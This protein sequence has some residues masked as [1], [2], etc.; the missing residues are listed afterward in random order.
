MTFR[1]GG[2]AAA[3]AFCTV[4]LTWAALPPDVVLRIEPREISLRGGHAFAWWIVKPNYLPE[5]LIA[6]DDVANP[7]S[8]HLQI[9][10]QGRPI[11]PAHALHQ[12]IEQAGS[13]RFSHWTTTL[14]F[15]TS[16]NTDPRT[17][18][19]SYEARVPIAPPRFLVAGAGALAALLAA[20]FL[21]RIARAPLV[22]MARAFA[23]RAVAF[24]RH[25]GALTRGAVALAGGAVAAAWRAG[26]ALGGAASAMVSIWLK[27][28][29]SIW[30]GAIAAARRIEVARPLLVFSLL[31][32]SGVIAWSLFPP[33]VTWRIDPTEIMPRAGH[34][35]AWTLPKPAL[36]PLAV[37]R[38][39]GESSRSSRLGLYQ[40]GHL[41]GPPHIADVLIADIGAG[42]Y[43]HWG[44]AILF[45]S[46]DNSDPRTNGHVYEA[47]APVVPAAWAIVAAGA[48]FAAA[49]VINWRRR[50]RGSASGGV[51][52]AR[53]AAAIPAAILVAAALVATMSLLGVL[54]GQ[55]IV[56]ASALTPDSPQALLAPA[57]RIS[58]KGIY[59]LEF[60]RF[61]APFLEIACCTQVDI[62]RGETPI[63]PDADFDPQADDPQRRAETIRALGGNRFYG[64]EDYLYLHLDS[65]PRWN[66]T[67]TLRF[68]V[69]AEPELIVILWLAAIGM[70]ALRRRTAR[71][72]LHP[73]SAAFLRGTA[74]AAASAAA[75]LLALSAIGL[76]V[77]L[78]SSEVDRP[79]R[80][81]IVRSHGPGDATMTWE[82][83]RT[84]LA[85]GARES[86]TAYA[87]RLTNVVAASVMHYWYERDRRAFRLQVPIWEN[88]LLWL[89]GEL[90][91]E[92]RLYA[93]ADPYK[94]IERGVGM[95]D[96]VSSAL[97]T[98]LRREGLDAR[99]VQL[100]GHTVVTAEVGAG[101]WHVL[102]ADY[103]VAIP[104]SMAQIQ[105]EPNMV[106]PY[107]QAAFNRLGPVSSRISLDLIASFYAPPTYIG[108]AGGNSA[109]GERRIA[110][111]A[112][113][114]WLKWRLPLA[115]LAFA[116][117][118]AAG[119][120]T[121]SRHRQ[122]QRIPTTR[123]LSP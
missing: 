120:R 61:Y 8:S 102:D 30:V 91:P 49:L 25:A 38:S 84:Q 123:E 69:K 12:E 76:L 28:I 119:L 108:E 67:L 47:R 77:P 94:A 88:Y 104:K 59:V 60:S 98:L 109:L 19:R 41:L 65:A 115:L 114:Y 23:D 122:Y 64:F 53:V 82:T 106:R 24:A 16:D 26:T 13:G 15:S 32:F 50:L 34:S 44:D 105:A 33:Q 79:S 73:T 89:A 6:G 95:C 70:L 113:A 97:V 48:L 40:D 78:R 121:T 110:F 35:F 14:I 5:A 39:N 27:A 81:T 7:Q 117:L 99:I 103:D 42:P 71:F 85:R 4:V 116:A 58:R 21:A 18:G 101:V 31:L 72:V 51:D 92:Y 52:W 96:Q 3:V 55:R 37:V 87:H 83:A 22:R 75:A 107:Y 93:F 112:L 80:A 9:Y 54:R 57:D 90:R 1:F 29:S 10:E 36:F 56:P 17:N 46:A 100:N 66:E 68:P 62:R 43:S 74:T 11:G 63:L 118:I 2:A 20:G 86:R 45:A 111:E